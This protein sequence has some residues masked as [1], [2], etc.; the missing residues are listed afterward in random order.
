MA[1]YL[2]SMAILVIAGALAWRSRPAFER[3]EG[4]VADGLTGYGW[5]S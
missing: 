3:D 4:P 2:L 5:G 1:H